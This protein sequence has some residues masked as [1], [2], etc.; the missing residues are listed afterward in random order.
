MKP[1][2]FYFFL[3]CDNLG[4]NLLVSGKALYYCAQFLYLFCCTIQHL[5]NLIPLP[6]SCTQDMSRVEAVAGHSLL[7]PFP[8]QTPWSQLRQLT[9]AVLRQ[10]KGCGCSLSLWLNWSSS[11]KGTP[12]VAKVY[13]GSGGNG[14]SVK[15]IPKVLLR[16]R[17]I[18]SASSP[19]SW[20][21]FE[22]LETITS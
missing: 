4:G 16:D 8:P 12:W 2:K 9:G 7:T 17:G 11:C 20:K 6:T 5:Q 10:G 14:Q 22:V 3:P 18:A 1:L 21:G 15:D 13:V 19:R